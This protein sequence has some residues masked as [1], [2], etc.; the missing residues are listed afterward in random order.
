MIAESRIEAANASKVFPHGDLMETILRL[1][2]PV[3]LRMSTNF[4]DGVYLSAFR[5]VKLIGT[6]VPPAF[7]SSNVGGS[8]VILRTR[9]SKFDPARLSSI[10]F[11]NSGV[12]THPVLKEN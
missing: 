8:V 1:H 10:P 4:Y 6:L 12:S 7:K 5:L 3:V 2:H 11:H 9:N